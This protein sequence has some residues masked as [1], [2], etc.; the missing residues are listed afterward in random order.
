MR[1]ELVPPL[2]GLGESVGA[3]RAE[4]RCATPADEPVAAV[5]PRES[6]VGR[7]ECKQFAWV[8]DARGPDHQGFG[9]SVEGRVAHNQ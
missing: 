3:G 7:K 8:I 9:R 5:H 6:V 1:G 4:L 2:G